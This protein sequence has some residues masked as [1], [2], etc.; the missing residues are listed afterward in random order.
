[1]AISAA[2]LVNGNP[3]PDAHDVAYGATVTLTLLST[4]GANSIVWEV[5]SRSHSDV[6]KPTLVLSG[7]PYGSTG[8]FTWI[9]DPSDTKGRSILVRVTVTDSAGTQV[10]EGAIIGTLASNGFMPFPAGEEQER[11]NELGWAEDL[12]DILGTSGGGGGGGY[13]LVQDEGVSVTV[14]TTMNFVGAGVSVA[15]TGGKTTVTIPG[16]GHTIEDEGTPLTQRT[17]LNFTGAGVSVADSGGKTVVTIAGGSSLNAPANPADD[18]KVAIASGGNLSY[19]LLANANV[20]A[21]AAIALSKLA[22]ISSDRLLGRDTA[23]SGAIEELTV[24]GGLEF[25]GSTGIQRSALTGDVTASAGSNTTAI[26]A[27]VI[28]NADINASAAIALSKLAAQ[29]ARSV[30]ANATNASAVPTAVAGGGANTVLVD[31]GTTLS[32]TTLGLSSLASVSALSVLGNGTNASAAVTA[33]TAGTDG[34]VMRR[35][36]TTVGFGSPNFAAQ[37]ITT[38]GA[39]SL[40]TS[41]AAAGDVRIGNNGSV[42]FRNNVGSADILALNVNTSDVL[43]L[44]NSTTGVLLSGTTILLRPNGTDR[45]ALTDTIAELRC[46]TF[47]FDTAVTTPVIIQEANS[48]NSATGQLLRITAQQTTGTSSTGGGL[49]LGSGPGTLADGNVTIKRGAT[50][51]LSATSTGTGIG[52]STILVE[53]ASLSGRKVVSLLRGSGVSATQVPSGDGILYIAY[54]TTLPTS[55]PTSGFEQFCDATGYYLRGPSGTVTQ[56]ALP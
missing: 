19:A 5:L 48:T 21:N 10:R 49:E 34:D 38:T 42:R 23:S 37:N 46:A 40:G 36:G 24:S 51:I 50:V 6:V 27:G 17:S 39:I 16:G 45:F 52:N 44:G 35:S 29:A 26:A 2:F 20:A 56:I 13:N 53:G 31:N 55:N 28:V 9:A 14:R 54:A 11:N 4:S 8:T 43:T 3:N 30:V 47:Q 12:N 41:P 25:T 1:M 7:T 18:G 22:N 33:L 15:D 32:F